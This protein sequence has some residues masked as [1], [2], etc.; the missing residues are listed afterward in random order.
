MSLIGKELQQTPRLHKHNG[1]HTAV[2]MLTCQCEQHDKDP[3]FHN[4]VRSIAL[5]GGERVDA[6]ALGEKAMTQESS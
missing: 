2:G 3:P 6:D 1:T 5:L 4:V